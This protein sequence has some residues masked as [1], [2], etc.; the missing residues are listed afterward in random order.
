MKS[1]IS[2][3]K[4]INFVLDTLFPS[5]CIGCGKE[6]EALCELCIAKIRC[7]ER[8]TESNIFAVF[9]YR[10][11][12]IKKVIWE[13]K[14][15]HKKYLSKKAGEL[16][17]EYL[18]EEIS[19]IRSMSSGGKIFVIPVPISKSKTRLRGYNQSLAI[20]KEFCRND[21]D[22]I[23]EIKDSLVIKKKETTPQARISN[24]NERI[25]NVEGVF[26]LSSPDNVRGKTFI[27]IDDVTTTG[28]TIKEIMKV[29]KKSGAKNVYGFTLAH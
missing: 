28:G 20:A 15:H 29:L 23:F 4:V 27:I 13:L 9:D 21:T 22:N 1:R 24:R 8:E 3:Q 7:A 10:D 6:N 5:F 14:Y 11:P 17:H 12:V 2:L 16:L 19:N 18:L 26:E 25:K